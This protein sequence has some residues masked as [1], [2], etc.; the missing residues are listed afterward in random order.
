MFEVFNMGVGF[1]YV[2]DPADADFTISILDF[3]LD[4]AKFDDR[5]FDFDI[6][7]FVASLVFSL[8]RFS[9]ED[10]LIVCQGNFFMA[11]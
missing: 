3:E 7:D 1:C 11:Q 10:R 2:V 4:F 6:T 5:N 9:N 8:K